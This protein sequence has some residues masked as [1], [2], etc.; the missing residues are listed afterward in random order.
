MPALSLLRKQ[1]TS[2]VSGHNHLF[3]IAHRTKPDGKR[4]WGIH[5]GC[6]L[7]KDQWEDYAGPANRLW[8]KGL[9]LLR[10]CENGDFESLETITVEGL[11]NDYS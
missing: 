1:L 10:G 11:E 8:W 3:D 6:F 7:A 2:C 5:A 4:V 9:I